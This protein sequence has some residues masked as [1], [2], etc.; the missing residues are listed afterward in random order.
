[1]TASKYIWMFNYEARL[2]SDTLQIPWSTRKGWKATCGQSTT[3]VFLLHP[4]LLTW[5]TFR[6][7][8]Y[9]SHL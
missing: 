3:D 6:E 9:T 5:I 1:M 2:K 8:A 4:T 7:K